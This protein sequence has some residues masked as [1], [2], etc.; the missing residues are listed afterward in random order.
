MIN[1]VSASAGSGKTYRLTQEYLSFLLNSRDIYEYKHILA[2]TFTNKATDEMKQRI[3]GELH[4]LS[5]SNNPNSQR[6]RKILVEILNDYSSFNISTID[7]F[8]QQTLRAFAREIGQYASYNVELDTN[9]VL[10]QSVNNMFDDLDS[11][12][13]LL[14]W[15][16][17]MSLHD[18][19]NGK[20]WNFTNHIL[21][22]GKLLFSEDYRV[23]AENSNSDLG[24]KATI[25]E[26]QDFL[27]K[28]I[29]KQESI[30][31]KIGKDAINIMHSNEL[32]PSDFSGGSRSAFFIFDKWANKNFKEPAPSFRKFIDNVDKWYSK[33]SSKKDLIINSYKDL[34]ELVNQL[35]ISYDDAEDYFTAKVLVNNISD[36]GVFSDIRRYISDYCTKNN[37]M[38]LSD[39]G[40]LLNRIIDGSDTPFIYEKIGARLNHYMLDEFQDTSVIQWRNFKPLLQDSIANGYDNLVVGDV[41]QSIYR[42]RGADWRLLNNQIYDDFNHS[43]VKSETL[44]YNWRSARKIVEFNNLFFKKTCDILQ[45][46]YEDDVSENNDILSK[47]YSDLEQK[48]PEKKAD[49]LDGHVSVSFLPCD[50]DWKE[51]ALEKLPGTIDSLLSDG[52][53]LNDILILVRINSDACQIADFLIQHNYNV[54]SD[55]ALLISSSN[56]IKK[57]VAELSSLLNTN[58]PINKYI[59]ERFNSSNNLLNNNINITGK[60]L[61]EICEELIRNLNNEEKQETIFLQA[62]L[63]CVLD[64]SSRHGTDI[65]GFIN[66][67]NETGVKVSV[68]APKGDAAISIMTVHKSKG[69][70]SKVVIMPFYKENIAMRNNVIWSIPSKAP[71]NMISP[72]PIV[73]NKALTKTIFKKDYNDELLFHY[74]DIIN[75]S[76]VAFTRAEEELIVFSPSP[77][78]ENKI[79]SISDILY[80]MRD[81]NTMEYELGKRI[82]RPIDKI[83][84]DKHQISDKKKNEFVSI[85][86]GERLK[87]SYRSKD[88]FTENNLRTKGIIMH[89]ILSKISNENEL[90]SAVDDALSHGL[91]G[92]NEY[93]KIYTTLQNALNSVKDRHWFDGTYSHYNEIAV[94]LPGGEMKRP[95]RVM[96]DDDDNAIIVDYKFGNIHDSSYICQVQNY[97]QLLKNMGYK[98]VAGYLWY[99]EELDI[100]PII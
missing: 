99:V 28:I 15:L 63:D 30:F 12:P 94:I 60:S 1:I 8:F 19:E 4:S 45:N 67:W 10:S 65:S 56:A 92:A 21:D 13:L 71:F 39:S 74:V 40:E 16:I 2:V 51:S 100:A 17:N 44:E 47:V 61:Y 95:D 29:D 59:L 87:L 77:K 6:A 48:I 90:K 36:L 14:D 35:C 52:Y 37:V 69:L 5:E 96:L 7:K 38:L 84:D 50:D 73:A 82:K 26:L 78:Y 20:N 43:Q 31:E 66:W 81:Q 3:V 91:I 68:S 85:A 32:E 72:L 22:F 76:Y 23:K 49:V 33:S 83:L 11:N 27:K 86:L 79:K 53:S 75:V 58:D 98:S 24:D 64:Y 25:L 54:I 34:N 55:E 57:I 18:I 97:M 41:K 46:V 80:S 42:W 89:D 93:D 9:E 88:Y 70:Q 62:F